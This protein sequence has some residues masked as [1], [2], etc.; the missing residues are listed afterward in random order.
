MFKLLCKTQPY[1]WGHKG[2]ESIVA[3]VLERNGKII[4]LLF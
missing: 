1:V 3:K 4:N 2:E